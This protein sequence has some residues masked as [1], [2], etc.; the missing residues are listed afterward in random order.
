MLE[1]LKNLNYHGGKAGLLFFICDV[2]GRNEITLR[3][4]EV[5]C[6][7]A[8]GKRQLSVEDLVCYCF[9]LGWIQKDGDVL[10]V[11]PSFEHLLDNKEAL[12]EELI[13]S[14]IEQLFSYSGMNQNMFSYD[15]IRNCYAFKNELFPLSLSCVRNILISQGFFIVVRD[16]YGTHFYIAPLF[17]SLVAK[18]CKTQRK[19][20]S[21][22]SLKKQLELNDAAGEKAELFV[23]DFEKS[24]LGKSLCER[25]KR[26]SE[27]DVSAGYDIISFNSNESQEHDRFIEVKAISNTGFYWSKNEYEIAKLKANSYYLY[28]VELSKINSFGYYPKMIQNPAESIFFSDEWFVETQSFFIHH[29]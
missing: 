19:Q 3:D 15:S 1:E 27:I 20:L 6:S 5:I 22:E 11:S 18:H 26:I 10:R 25:I 7:H 28:L 24:R 12:N 2:I 21:L 9:T 16:S 14:T 29:V 4:A 17:E 13:K 23:L 8:S